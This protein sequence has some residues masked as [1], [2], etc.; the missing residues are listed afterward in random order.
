[1]H[2]DEVAIDARLVRRLVASQFPEWASLSLDP[3]FPL[4]TD[5]ANYRLGDELVVRL[6]RIPRSVSALEKEVE[7]LPRLALELPLAAPVPVAVAEP[8]DGFPFPWAVYT[9]LDGEPATPERI[10]DPDRAASDLARFLAALRAVDAT[11]GPGPGEHNVFRGEPLQLR[12]EATRRAL[13]PLGELVDAR[14]VATVW[15]RALAVPDWDGPPVWIHGDLDSR[16]LLARDGGLSGVLDWGCLGV[17][18]PACD[19]MVAWKTLPVNARASF[20]AELEVD[21]A[22]WAR[23][24]GWALSQALGALAYYT[25]KTNAVLVAE[26]RRWLHEVL[27]DAS[28]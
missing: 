11:G 7:W 18:D 24:Y 4:G 17:G 27:A 15:D 8:G 25:E 14:V 20:R 5:N 28:S 16:N 23:A 12:D 1:M 9:W 22:T 26:A 19:V 10:A 21:D 6:P 2:A 3:V 13:R